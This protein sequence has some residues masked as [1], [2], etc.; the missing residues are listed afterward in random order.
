MALVVEYL[1]LKWP[2]SQK[3]LQ[4]LDQPQLQQVR[5]DPPWVAGV[6]DGVAE[7]D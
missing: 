4:A 2:I 3:P 1:E 5:Q 6:L 7:P